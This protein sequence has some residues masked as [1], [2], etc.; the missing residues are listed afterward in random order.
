MILCIHNS[1]YRNPPLPHNKEWHIWFIGARLGY[2]T[3]RCEEEEFEFETE[4]NSGRRKVTLDPS[5]VSNM[6]N[7]SDDESEEEVDSPR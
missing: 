3:S 2:E 5:L 6:L 7:F 4:D 1:F